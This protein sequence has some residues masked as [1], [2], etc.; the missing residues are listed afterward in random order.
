MNNICD[1]Q[2]VGVGIVQCY[3][4][5]VVTRPLTGVSGR[6]GGGCGGNGVPVPVPSASAATY[7]GGG[8][9]LMVVV[10]VVVVL[11]VVVVVSSETTGN[12]HLQG[13]ASS[14]VRHGNRLALSCRLCFTPCASLV[15]PCLVFVF[16]IV[17]TLL[18]LILLPLSTLHPPSLL[19]LVALSV[20]C[21]SV[22]IPSSSEAV[23]FPVQLPDNRSQPPPPRQLRTP[24]I[25]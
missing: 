21:L 25:T 1:H 2:G 18:S 23:S 7:G 12:H 17:V 24:S 6:K 8:G 9:G 10:V 19:F 22:R 20:F 3:D 5:I 4:Q 13:Q 11:V 15:S 16:S 14:F